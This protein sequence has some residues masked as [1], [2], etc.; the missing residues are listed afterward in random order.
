MTTT[1]TVAKAT[2]SAIPEMGREEKTLYYLIVGEGEN[3]VVIN[4]GEKNYEAIKNLEK[5]QNVKK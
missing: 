1:V 3:K 2:Q 4:T 5:K